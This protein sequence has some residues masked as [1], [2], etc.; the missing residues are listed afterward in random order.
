M[1][2]PESMCI[3][4]RD[5]RLVLPCPAFAAELALVCLSLGFNTNISYRSQSHT[6][7]ASISTCKSYWPFLHSE[8]FEEQARNNFCI[9]KR[10]VR[11]IS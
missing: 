9:F 2:L 4:E 5:G 1:H 10:H 7:G 11:W 6:P 8:V 3:S